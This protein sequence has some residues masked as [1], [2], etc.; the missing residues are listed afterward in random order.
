MADGHGT[1]I[2]FGTSGFSANLIAVN[3]FSATRAEVPNTHMGTADAMDYLPAALYDWDAD[4]TV[5]H[6]A[7]IAVPIDRPK[8]TITFD[9][10]GGGNTYAGSGF[11]TGYNS[12]AAVGE[13]ME[14]TLTIKG[15]GAVTGLV[16]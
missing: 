7:S 15:S 1:T 12:G 14:S 4:I 16:A 6:D 11:V 9:W 2:T 5:E 3:S 13:R 8:E 10:A